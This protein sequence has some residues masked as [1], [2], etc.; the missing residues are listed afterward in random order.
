MESF[1]CFVKGESMS[2]KRLQVDEAARNNTEGFRVLLENQ[3]C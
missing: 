2:E 1:D 3:H